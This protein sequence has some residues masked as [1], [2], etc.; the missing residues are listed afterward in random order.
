MAV[1][2]TIFGSLKLGHAEKGAVVF[3]IFMGT[4][5]VITSIIRT[6]VFVGIP[7]LPSFGVKSNEIGPIEYCNAIIY[8]DALEKV[9]MYIAYCLP[10]MKRVLRSIFLADFFS[11]AWSVFDS[12]LLSWKS[13][14]MTGSTSSK[15]RGHGDQTH[16]KEVELHESNDSQVQL[17]YPA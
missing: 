8:V 13:K 9:S 1:P 11:K 4:L 14:S 16:G 17:N 7:L 10:A 6:A 5:S 12:T 3:V 2:L 15:S